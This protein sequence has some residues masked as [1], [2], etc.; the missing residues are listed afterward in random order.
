MDEPFPSGMVEE[1]RRVLALKLPP[2]RLVYDE[3]INSPLMF[4]LQRR[5]EML[6]MLSMV[7]CREPKTVFEIGADKGGS[8]YH[9]CQIPSV[10]NVAACEIRGTPYA[11]AFEE[12]FPDKNFF[13]MPFGSEKGFDGLAKTGWKIDVLFID[14]DKGRFYE[15]FELYLP[16]M[17][18]TGVVLFHDVQDTGGPRDA[19]IKAR[20]GRLDH[21]YLY[22]HDYRKIVE[23][24]TAHDQWLLHW[25]GRSCGVGVVFMERS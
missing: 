7:S 10:K 2:G 14:G 16:L 13:W 3:V 19:W 4:P 23:P 12:A 24:K 9:W 22:R 8:L 25:A 11:G 17:S 1:I 20:K 21:E 18:E 15:D 5:S 6:A